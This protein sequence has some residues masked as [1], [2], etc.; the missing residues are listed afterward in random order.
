MLEGAAARLQGDGGAFIHSLPCRRWQ[1]AERFAE[2]TLPQLQE[3]PSHAQKESGEDPGAAVLQ[4]WKKQ[5]GKRDSGNEEGEKDH[6]H[7]DAHGR[8]RMYGLF[9]HV[10]MELL[11]VRDQGT[12]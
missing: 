11:Q 12:S 10:E 6:I 9:V 8:G 7:K 4:G 3:Q 2:K 5:A 1:S